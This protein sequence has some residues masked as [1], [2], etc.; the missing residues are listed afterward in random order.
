MIR[1]SVAAACAV[2]MA[3]ACMAVG[4]GA[5]AG[6][7]ASAGGG[8]P[9]ATAESPCDG[10]GGIAWYAGTGFYEDNPTYVAPNNGSRSWTRSSPGAQG[11]DAGVLSRGIA[12]LA[13][14]GSLLSVLI[15]R[16][17]RLV[18]ERYLHGGGADHA[19]NVHSASKSM[20]QALLSIAVRLG[21]IHSLDD[22]V[23]TYLPRYFT[24]APA[25]ERAI[26]IRD[27]LTMSSGLHWVEDNTEYR[28]QNTSNWLAAI[29][30]QKM[31]DAPGTR[32]DYSTGDFH[33]LSAVLQSA[34]GMTTCAFAEHYLFSPIGIAPQHWG[35]DPTTGTDMGGC[36]LYMTP[37]DMAAFGLLYLHGGT[38]EGRRLVPSSAIRDA[39]RPVWD[40]GGGF[41]YSQGWW[42]RRISGIRMYF[43]WGYGGQFIYVIPSLDVVFVT[44]EDTSD[45]ARHTEID[46][47]SFIRDFLI[48][49]VT[50]AGARA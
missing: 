24:G 48:P 21:Y 15:V 18:E 12:H 42:V 5:A 35:V 6:S 20:L 39:A 31:R 46:S 1:P 43:A 23:S 33:V 45:G 11:M 19:N 4:F 41:H 49:S 7:A 3:L 27:L 47:G 34:T 17:D 22:R 37:R 38:S 2:A 29:L 14:N 10:S 40:V 13:T 8:T 50:S 44:S 36:D 26:T 30:G 28:V 32:F 16:H 25:S 9:R